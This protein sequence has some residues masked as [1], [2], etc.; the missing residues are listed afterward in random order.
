V[1][2]GMAVWPSHG[3]KLIDVLANWKH[4]FSHDRSA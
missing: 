4:D 2:N 1:D 3:A